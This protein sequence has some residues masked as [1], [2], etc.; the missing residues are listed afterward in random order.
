MVN[1]L[2]R[3][4]P[5]RRPSSIPWTIYGPAIR[6]TNPELWAGAQQG[7]RRSQIRHE[8]GDASHSQF[9]DV[10]AVGGDTARQ[11]DGHALLFSLLRLAVCR[12]KVLARRP[13]PEHRRAG[14]VFPATR[15][16]WRAGQ[17]PDP[18]LKSYF[19]T[20]FRPLRA[21]GRRVPASAAANVTMPQLLS[22]AKT[23]RQC[24]RFRAGDGR[25]GAA[26]EREQVG[27]GHHRGTVFLLTLSRARRRRRRRRR[28]RRNWLTAATREEV[29]R[30]PLL[31]AASTRRNLRSIIESGRYL[32][33]PNS[34]FRGGIAN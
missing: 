8:T 23:A 20:L 32:S 31:G 26:P 4:L 18:T 14:R 15:S 11:Q 7:I 12:P 9:A 29:L 21:R 33:F 34:C 1:R 16:A 6:R 3:A 25:L 2:W 10:S 13:V 30:D 19:L 17:L 27:R 22:P 24:A 28:C 5:R